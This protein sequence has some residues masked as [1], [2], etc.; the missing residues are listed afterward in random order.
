MAGK[1]SRRVPSL[2]DKE[3]QEL[4]GMKNRGETPKIRQRAHAILLSDFG[5]SVNE[6]ASILG[7]TRLT[8]CSWFA[9]WEKLG[10]KGLADA[11]RSGAPPKLSKT[12]INR[13]LKLIKTHP[14]S[15]KLVLMDI[16]KTIGKT[17]SGSTLRRLA[18]KA[19]LRWK[20]A[21]KSLK[22][23]R[24]EEE[25]QQAGEEIDELIE[26]HQA[27]EITLCYFDEAGFSLTPTVPYAWQPIGETLEIPSSKSKQLNVLG[28]LTYDGEL[29]SFTVE[30]SVDSD[31][32]ITCF[33]QFAESLENETTVLI[34]NAPVHTSGKF[35]SRIPL[36]EEKGLNLW[37]LPA[38][39]PE[40]NFIEMLWRMI[41]Y[42]WIPLPAYEC[43]TKLVSSLHQ[44][45]KQVGTK[46]TIEF[47]KHRKAV[48]SA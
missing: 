32:V 41:K 7:V 8:V 43:F 47:T 19:G 35:E 44:V 18:R 25:F 46:Y 37:F 28:F 20:R 1:P 38:Y 33:D 22:S 5:R 13:V 27:G 29:T 36:W 15:P 16:P 14:H 34:D 24:D 11:E 45:L 30:G 4:Q 2:S 40:L 9:R 17:I 26:F 6:I 48:Y 42:H 21:R 10:S 3:R 12:E 31:I 39:C 23:K